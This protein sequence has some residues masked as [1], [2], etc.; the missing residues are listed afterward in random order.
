MAK[1]KATG[2]SWSESKVSDAIE[3]SRHNSIQRNSGSESYDGSWVFLRQVPNGTSS[4]KTNTADAIAVGCWGSTGIEL[5]GY[6]M[7]ISRSDFLSELQDIKKAEAFTK[8]C[9]YWF[10]AAPDGIAKPEELPANWG[11]VVV[12][13]DQDG[14]YSSRVRKPATR[15]NDAKLDYYFFAAVLRKA[16]RDCPVEEELRKIRKREF[17]RG[18]KQ[19][20]KAANS[21]ES[22]ELTRIKRH[23]HESDRII[24][25]FEDATGISLRYRWKSVEDIG[26][27][28]K[29]IL[30]HGARFEKD[31]THVMNIVERIKSAIDEYRKAPSEEGNERQTDVDLS[32]LG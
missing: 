26:K 6:E 17:D 11:L 16:R 8:H 7:K 14:V 29:F 13:V 10:I 27:A 9:H 2:F 3:A 31:F 24:K 18:Y 25:E 21:P 12:S 15:N 1:K 19:G 4:R 23:L 5:T 32:D 20:E 22:Y 28:V 30:D